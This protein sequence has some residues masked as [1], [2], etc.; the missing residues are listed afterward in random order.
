MYKTRFN[1]I[2]DV[3][4]L[5]AS[6]L[7]FIIIYHSIYIIMFISYTLFQCSSPRGISPWTI[8]AIIIRYKNVWK[9]I[10]QKKP[11][12][13]GNYICPFWNIWYRSENCNFSRVSQ[14]CEYAE[15]LESPIIKTENPS[16]LRNTR[17]LEYYFLFRLY[18]CIVITKWNLWIADSRGIV[19]EMS[20]IA[21]KTN[22][23]I[24][25]AKF[26]CIDLL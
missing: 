16:A 19:S 14:K 22:K 9:I 8:L 15:S 24:R 25:L 7:I 10:K 11:S 4:N 12:T 2:N 17:Y 6:L 13:I 1:R 23:I 3:T 21:G 18:A 5:C 20:A 26:N